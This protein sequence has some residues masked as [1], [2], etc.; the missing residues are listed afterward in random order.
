MKLLAEAFLK[1]SPRVQV[2][3]EQNGQEAM[4]FFLDIASTSHFFHGEEGL[5]QSAVSL[6]RDLGFSAQWACAD[7]P[8]GAQ[9]FAASRP[10]T[11]CPPGEEREWLKDL[12]LP[13]LLQLEGVEPWERPAAIESIVTFFMMLGF[14][15]A[16]DLS[17]FTF[18]S[19]Q[20]RWGETGA[21]LWRRLNAKDRQ[22]IS[23]LNST[24][25]LEDF[26]HLG[27]PVSLTSILLL[28]MEKSLDFLF[29]RLQGRRLVARKIVLTLH[30]EY[31]KTQ[32]KIEIEPNTPSRDRDLFMTLLENRLSKINLENPIRDFEVVVIPDPEKARQFDFFEPR[33]T[34]QDRV[35]SLLSLLTQSSLKPGF[36][37]IEPAILPEETWRIESQPTSS[38]Q[39]YSPPAHSMLA[40]R[41]GKYTE[42]AM[43]PTPHYGESVMRAPRPTRLLA[44]PRRMTSEDLHPLKIL[45]T[46][47]IERLEDAWWKSGSRRDY[48]FAIS[49]DGQCL[50]IYQDLQTEEYFLHGYF[51]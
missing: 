28:Q 34:D 50:W 40:E 16:G 37:H 5:T 12:S 41:K 22:V 14:E 51:D 8:A 31:S 46:H 13:H 44:K 26:V 47:P 20:E 4:L 3:S 25:P 33:N 24:E 21:L 36:Y 42:P 27:F 17:R 11:I 49:P 48:Y 15:T 2:R 23:P 18:A 29:A 32:Y 35:Q 43:T 38:K 1:F 7:T 45:S 19:L 6:A 39:R 9:A 30:C 10:N